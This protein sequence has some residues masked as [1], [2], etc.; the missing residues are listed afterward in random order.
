M[1]YKIPVSVVMPCFNN[2]KFV[3]AAIDSLLKQT[4]KDFELIVVDDGSTDLSPQIINAFQDKR[5]RYFRLDKNMGNYTARNAGIRL[6]TGK[7]I[8]MMDADDISLPHRLHKQVHFMEKNKNI[9]CIGALS[10]TIDQDGIKIKIKNRR[11]FNYPALKVALFKDNYLLQST[12]MIRNGLIKKYNLWYNESFRYSGD[13][14]FTVRCAEKFPVC[15]LNEILVQYRVHP[16][17]I[18]SSKRQEQMLAA[19][20]V[21]LN[22]LKTLEVAPDEDDIHLHLKLMNG[23]LLDK[24]ELQSAVNWLNRV[25][26]GNASKKIY[27]E[28][29]LFFFLQEM[30]TLAYQK[31]H[32]Q[33]TQINAGT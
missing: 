16:S 29:L 13:Y 33:K 26:E 23:M 12:I 6:A 21:R 11:P 24:N 20:K 22:Q 15:N 27:N 7:Y 25:I 9:G 10:D 17:Q 18:S 8:C 3:A 31:S 4:F 14:D 30:L 1:K 28:K 2:E 5:I 19:D 32:I